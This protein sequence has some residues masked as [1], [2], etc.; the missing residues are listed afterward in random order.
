MSYN[1]NA[2]T[3]ETEKQSSVEVAHIQ[4]T[5]ETELFDAILSGQDYR[6][7]A[8]YERTYASSDEL[9][10]RL[11]E[12]FENKNLNYFKL[13]AFTAA[14]VM[15]NLNNHQNALHHVDV[16]DDVIDYWDDLIKRHTADDGQLIKKF[17][18]DELL[19]IEAH[20]A[21][22]DDALSDMNWMIGD[23]E[24]NSLFYLFLM[25]NTLRKDYDADPS[26][27]DKLTL[28]IG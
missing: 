19:T 21:D 6:D 20:L 15:R 1:I 5:N 24:G 2:Y 18:V 11:V 28:S 26:D 8:G 23:Y 17:S 22:F 7:G 25:V 10:T 12:V 16:D 4:T 27:F 14:E 13:I 9:K 3:P